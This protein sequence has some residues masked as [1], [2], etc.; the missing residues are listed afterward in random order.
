MATISPCARCAN[1]EQNIQNI[2]HALV[3]WG[4][5]RVCVCVCA[6]HPMVTVCVCAQGN[7]HAAPPRAPHKH[8]DELL[9]VARLRAR[10]DARVMVTNEERG[11]HSGKH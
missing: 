8:L 3:A 6:R 4:G 11:L 10:E 9:L 1:I 2:G 5:G 7:T